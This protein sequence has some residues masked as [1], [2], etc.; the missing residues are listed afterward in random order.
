V[1]QNHGS[2]NGWPGCR[3]ES[4]TVIIPTSQ[5][6]VRTARLI[7]FL[8]LVTRVIFV[9]PT[10]T[11]KSKDCQMTRQTLLKT[12]VSSPVQPHGCTSVGQSSSYPRSPFPAAVR[13]TRPQNVYADERHQKLHSS[14][15]GGKEHL[16]MYQPD[17]PTME[18]IPWKRSC[19]AKIIFTTPGCS[20]IDACLNK[21]SPPARNTR[22]G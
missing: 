21:A 7:C 10:A 16:R 17:M 1:A 11:R 14:L 22:G 18:K 15:K 12:R 13:G 3:R 20:W 2:R 9:L 8:R 6:S 19:L 5:S 4:M